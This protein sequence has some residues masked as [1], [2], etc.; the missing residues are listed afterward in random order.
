MHIVK[1]NFQDLIVIEPK[2]WGDSRGYFMESFNEKQLLD[3]GYTYNWIQDNE[4]F[5]SRGVLRGL[6]YQK[7]P[8][9]QTKLVRVVQGEVLDVV[10]D[11]RKDSATY[12]K[13]FSLI[14]SATNKKQLL[15]PKGF[16]HGY[17]VLSATALFLYKVDN[18]YNSEAEEGI[19]Y[20]DP[21]LKI[22]W[23]LPHEE[24]VLSE[25]DS[26]NHTFKNHISYS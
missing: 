14:L 8:F 13:S 6:H 22:D 18:V 16:A 26:K 2:V 15:V 20:N 4:S 3:Q 12:G 11:I 17:I 9:G 25:K 19:I 21:E 10:V 23:I 7:A 1:T 24:I 5:S